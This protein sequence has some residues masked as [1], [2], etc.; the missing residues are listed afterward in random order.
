VKL[1]TPIVKSSQGVAI[2]DPPSERSKSFPEYRFDL[3]I[4]PIDEA[5][6]HVSTECQAD[7][8]GDLD[9]RVIDAQFLYGTVPVSRRVELLRREI[10]D[11]LNGN[12]GSFDVRVK[13]PS[14][15]KSGP[16]GCF[17]HLQPLIFFL[18][19]WCR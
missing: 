9:H 19:I 11:V 17:R 8:S 15:R 18:W 14:A 3:A 13:R 16:K 12:P 4:A 6:V 10:R 2:I 7:N 5:I 1:N